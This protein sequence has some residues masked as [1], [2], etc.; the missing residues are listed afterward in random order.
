MTEIYSC[1][2]TGH[3]ARC[4]AIVTAAVLA[5][6]S[7]PTQPIAGPPATIRIVSGA[8]QTA[9][10]GQELPQPIV[11]EVRDSAQRPIGGAAI[12]GNEDTG[13]VGGLGKPLGNI[14]GDSAITDASGRASIRW[15]L[16][17]TPA[18][19]M[20]SFVVTPGVVRDPPPGWNPP[21]A[22]T[23][24][25]A[26]AG[27]LDHFTVLGT[28]RPFWLAGSLI[29][30]DTLFSPRDVFDNV[31]PLPAP[32]LSATNGWRVVGDTILPPRSRTTGE[33]AVTIQSGDVTASVAVV[34]VEDL[35]KNRWHVTW[36]CAG[37]TSTG[38]GSPADSVTYDAYSRVVAYV[39]DKDYYSKAGG[40]LQWYFGSG[41]LR[42]VK[43]GT[44]T[45]ANLITSDP[46]LGTVTQLPDTLV[47]RASATAPGSGGALAP[48]D[49]SS[50]LPR[51][52][53]GSWCDPTLYSVRPPMVIEAY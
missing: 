46:W 16:A 30:R 39:G 47:Q 28:W 49:L 18:A 14:V 8:N 17:G 25:T 44:A 52:V 31:L 22:S 13:F 43:G 32:M 33:T 19:M 36:S 37:P 40:N 10:V 21:R 11:V 20:L 35:R 4:L 6:C 9:T 12:F 48:R 3:S 24:A 7:D 41:T 23:S 45:I 26:L 42:S 50:T 53:G 27:P 29:R 1:A 5:G 34:V 2:A 38:P 51:Y 15:R